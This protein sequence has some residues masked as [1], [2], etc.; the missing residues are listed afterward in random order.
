[1]QKEKSHFNRKIIL[2]IVTIAL[3]LTITVGVVVAYYVN[4]D[5]N[6]NQFTVGENE[7]KITEKFEPPSNQV[8][9]S[10]KYQKKIQV[11]NTGSVP[12]YVRLYVSF[13]NSQVLDYSKFSDAENLAD[14]TIFYNANPLNSDS[15]A[16]YLNS[17]GYSG[18]WKYIKDNTNI[19]LNGYYYYTEPIEP[20][21]STEPLFNWIDTDYQKNGKDIQQYEVL[22]YSET[23]QSF[24][25][26]ENQSVGSSSSS[27]W[28]QAWN[29]FLSYNS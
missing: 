22:V 3:L 1:M 25:D 28:L 12:C 5:K 17:G 8:E 13:S 14:D 7:N 15:F 29:S 2:L 20:N 11:E 4:N 10:N 27:K 16:D 23:L 6:N 26:N 18:K 9:T 19:N 24:D 21:Q